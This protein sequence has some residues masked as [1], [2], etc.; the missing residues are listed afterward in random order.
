M[1]DDSVHG[2]NSAVS[3]ESG[4]VTVESDDWTAMSK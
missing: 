4:G 3:L 1:A 2:P